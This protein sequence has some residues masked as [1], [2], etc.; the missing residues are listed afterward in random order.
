MVRA[1]HIRLLTLAEVDRAFPLV[2][3]IYPEA[4]LDAWQDF[5]GRRIAGRPGGPCGILSVRNEQDCIV[6]LGC[7]LHSDDLFHGEVLHGEIFCALDIIGQD[8]IAR[9]LEDG[10]THIARRHGCKA[11]HISL[12]PDAGL[13][14][15]GWISSLLYERGHHL[16]NLQMCKLLSDR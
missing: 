2:R 8:R 5:A 4:R 13:R 11:V 1:L 6:G 12:P 15:D 16:E 10:F 7:Y 3:E 9:T 14:D